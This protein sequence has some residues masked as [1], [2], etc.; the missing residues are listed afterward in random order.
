MEES[1]KTHRPHIKVGKDEEK[2]KKKVVIVVNEQCNTGDPLE[3]SGGLYRGP[4]TML[5]YSNTIKCCACET[6]DL[7]Q[8]SITMNVNINRQFSLIYSTCTGCL[9]CTQTCFDVP[10]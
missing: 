8:I 2:K 6:L 5:I 9:R 7:V 4:H 10:P 3:T 1:H